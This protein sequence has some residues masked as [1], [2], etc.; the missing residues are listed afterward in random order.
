M[1]VTVAMDSWK[2]SLTSLNAGNAVKAVVLRAA[3]EAYVSV[4]PMADG[5]EGTAKTL[6]QAMGGRME[7]ITVTGPMGEPVCCSYGIWKDG[8]TAVMEM[9]AAAGIT[10][11]EQGKRNPM[12]ATTYGVGEMIRDAVLKGCR[13]FIIGIGG[14]ATNDGG[15]GMLQA[16]GFRFLDSDGRPVPFGALGLKTLASVTEGE[17]LGALSECE[18]RIACD[19]ANVLC[20]P[21]GASAVYGPQKGATR[22]MTEQMDLW[23][24]RYAKLVQRLYPGADPNRAG[25]GAAGGLGFAFLSFLKARLEP[26]VQIV[27]EE[28]G[29]AERIKDADLVITGEGRL[30]GQTAMGKVPAGVA[31][32]AKR[33]Q[34]PVVALAGSVS[35]GAVQGREMG[36]DASFPVLREV[37]TLEEAMEPER[38]KKNIADTAEQVASLFLA[39]RETEAGYKRGKIEQTMDRKAFS[40]EKRGTR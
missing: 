23:M 1:R 7:Q 27:L 16:L 40:A 30:D 17:A 6:V 9:A 28:T 24:K 36:I 34:K 15:V 33:Y 26:G 25:A 11:V 2:G 19:V 20:G 32:L 21:Q 3:P 22:Q 14:S 29:L 13:R 8:V 18:F 35:L 37:I 4:C 38:A 10:L 31:A 5:G 12:H 39:G